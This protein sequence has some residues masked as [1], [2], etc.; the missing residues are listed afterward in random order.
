V[1]AAERAV[2]E[3]G[4][5]RLVD[6]EVWQRLRTSESADA[7][8]I[9]IGMAPASIADL[10]SRASRAMTDAGGWCHATISR[11]ILRCVLPATRTGEEIT[12]LRGIISELRGPGSRVVERLPA[13]L[14]AD[15]PSAVTD[16]LSAN[17]RRTFDPD[18]VLNPGILDPS[19]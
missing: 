2:S 19:A 18:H 12:H 8:V 16:P 6:T 11:G 7:T 1:R 13:A 5:T 9:R 15:E 14:W 3:L 4:S 17:V 10:W